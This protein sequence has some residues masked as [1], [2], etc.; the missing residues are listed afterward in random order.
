MPGLTGILTHVDIRQKSLMDY[1][2][3][4]VN[5]RLDRLCGSWLIVEISSQHVEFAVQSTFRS[6]NRN[7]GLAA[8]DRE[9]TRRQA[10]LEVRCPAMIA[11]YLNL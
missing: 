6:A 1:E 5:A 9:G 8:D 11:R 10:G 7:V 3:G 4:P 2:P